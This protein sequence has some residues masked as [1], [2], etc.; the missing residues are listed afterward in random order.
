R[1]PQSRPPHGNRPGRAGA[2]RPGPGP[3]AGP[4][5]A[6]NSCPIPLLVYIYIPQQEFGHRV[7]EYSALQPKEEAGFMAW[8]RGLGRQSSGARIVVLACLAG[9][10]LLAGAVQAQTVQ[11]VV[12]SY[13]GAYDEVFKQYIVEPFEQANPGVR[14]V[15][16]PYATVTNLV[17]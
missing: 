5:G 9:V 2:G 6:A 8:L 13:G 12:S 1:R 11:L 16:A 4:S 14:V 15:L 10:L 3:L 7:R 17:A